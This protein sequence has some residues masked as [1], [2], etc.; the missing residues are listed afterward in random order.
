MSYI[1]N[2]LKILQAPPME[3]IRIGFTNAPESDSPVEISDTPDMRLP[4]AHLSTR[5]AEFSDDQLQE[6]VSMFRRV[7]C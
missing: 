5:D 7:M 4:E 2:A 6:L 1:N 3:S